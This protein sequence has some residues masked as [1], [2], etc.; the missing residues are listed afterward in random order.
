MNLAAVI[1]AICTTMSGSF[2]EAEGQMPTRTS[3]TNG[4]WDAS[5]ADT[6]GMGAGIYPGAAD[7]VVIDSGDT[8]T[9]NG[10]TATGTV[11]VDGTLAGGGQTLTLNGGSGDGI[12]FRQD[13]T[14]SGVLH[15]TAAN[16]TGVDP[17]RF[18]DTGGTGNIKNLH[19]PVTQ[20]APMIQM[21]I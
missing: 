18:K 16:G 13:G 12:L 3:Q 7:H 2:E 9:L 21:V 6:W 8:V 20:T 15:I 10:A 5:D 17:T 14:I 11:K 4:L 19:L 1:L